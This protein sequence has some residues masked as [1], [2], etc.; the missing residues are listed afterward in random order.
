MDPG[1]DEGSWVFIEKSLEANSNAAADAAQHSLSQNDLRH[2]LK[3]VC[4]SVQWYSFSV[5]SQA[6]TPLKD[7][8]SFMNVRAMSRSVELVHTLEELIL[9]FRSFTAH[10]MMQQ[11]SKS[12][13][14]SHAKMLKSTLHYRSKMLA[15]RK[16]AN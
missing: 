15:R 16:K 1:D 2:A 7:T 12:K 11:P 5:F 3:D 4:E 9:H 14:V 8:V 6:N 10:W 13:K